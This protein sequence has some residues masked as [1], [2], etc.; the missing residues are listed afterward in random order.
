MANR[1]S[2]Y[3]MTSSLAQGPRPAGQQASQVSTTTLL[4]ALHTSYASGQPYQLESGASLAINTW[5]TT[6]TPAPNGQVGGTFDFALG[7]R[8]WEH[9]RRRAE[10]GCIVLW[11]VLSSSFLRLSWTV[12]IN[13]YL[14]VHRMHPL[15]LFYRLSYHPY[16]YQHPE[17]H[18]LR[19]LQFDPLFPKSR[20]L[21]QLVF[22]TLRSR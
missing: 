22:N 11:Y 2:V 14:V 6:S 13:S 19:Y 5:V 3:S 10:D 12:F 18:I 7:R 20:P 8:A 15:P 21:T 1:M 17:S 9:S 4:N 16:L